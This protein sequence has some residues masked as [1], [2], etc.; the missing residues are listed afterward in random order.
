MHRIEETIERGICI[1]CG[2]CSVITADAV[3]IR[4]N[5]YGIFTA[6]LSDVPD[7]LR[8][9]ASRVCPFSDEAL[10]ENV[11]G[12][13]H[14]GETPHTI[15]SRV[16][17]YT[18]AFVARVSDEDYA[19]NSS[20]G[21]LTSWLLGELH[22]RGD[23]DAFISVGSS[24][25]LDGLFSYKVTEGEKYATVR[26]SAYY[27][28]TLNEALN[29]VKEKDKKFA[30]VGVP[31][32]VKAVR[33]LCTQDPV[34]DERISVFIG[35]LCGHMK[36]RNFGP[37]LAWQL[38]IPPRDIQSVDFRVKV[39]G[40][41][42]SQYNFAAESIYGEVVTAP[43]KDLVGANW[44]YGA[45]QPEACNFC[46]DVFAETADVVF[47]DAWLPEYTDDWLGRNIVVSRNIL[48]D[49]IIREGISNGTLLG[50]EVD[51]DVPVRSQ[52]GNFRHRRQGLAVRLADDISEGLSVPKKRVA[53]NKLAVPHSRR[54]LI[55][56]RR[57][58]SRLSLLAYAEATAKDDLD[59]YLECMSEEIKEYQ[60]IQK[61][62]LKHWW[63]RLRNLPRKITSFSR[64]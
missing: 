10:S 25:D 27:A 12:A 40:R 16:G 51:V 3:P 1:G 24:E 6:D 11:L 49:A 23:I 52:L 59:L 54:M 14:L 29:L 53:P 44:G 5:E 26:K 58:M 32:F 15:D 39:P 36:T 34:L 37:S 17:Q 7:E 61:R 38:G 47:G 4:L 18:A 19:V 21:G 35:L 43:T 22:L 60:R 55:R 63:G 2:A 30:L 31:C 8:R 9:Q 57:R 20:S 33:L 46:D 13:P 45:F 62:S 41:P 48:V 64:K 50:E 42:S 56:Q 28:S